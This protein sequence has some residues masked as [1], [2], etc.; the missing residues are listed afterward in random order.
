MTSLLYIDFKYSKTK[1][2][3]MSLNIYHFL[4]N[5]IREFDYIGIEIQ[6]IDDLLCIQN[7][8]TETL[9]IV[10]M[11]VSDDILINIQNLKQPSIAFS[12]YHDCYLKDLLCSNN[13]EVSF[14]LSENVKN[15]KFEHLILNNI[16]FHNMNIIYIENCFITTQ[17]LENIQQIHCN[18]IEFVDC[19]FEG[20]VNEEDFKHCENVVID[21]NYDTSD[22]SSESDNDSSESESDNDSSESESDND[23][24]NYSSESD[25]DSSNYSSDN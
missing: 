21:I 24:S 20:D 19:R 17:T 14:M 2:G 23:S 13:F 25:N 15:V 7:V 3:Y 4:Q 10:F 22:Y 12:S 6:N 9:D 16:I 11:D 18:I 5:T 1:Y 8:N